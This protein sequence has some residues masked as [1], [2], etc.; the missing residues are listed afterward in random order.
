MNTFA[1]SLGTVYFFL[2]AFFYSQAQNVTL[3]SGPNLLIPRTFH[4][5]NT[6]PN[7]NL[8]IMGGDDGN[9]LNRT[10]YASTEI[11][12]LATNTISA[13]PV[14]NKN[15]TQ[16]CSEQLPNGNILVVAGETKSGEYTLSAEILNAS[17]MTWSFTD[18]IKEFH[19]KAP[20][21]TKMKDG[22]IMI[23][24][25]TTKKVEIFDP[26]TNKWT[27][28][29]DMLFAHGEGM[30]LTLTSNGNIYAMGG[31]GALKT[32]EQ[33]NNSTNKWEPR[34]NTLYSRAYHKV[35]FISYDYVIIT[36]CDPTVTVENGKNYI[37]RINLNNG[38]S[39]AVYN[40]KQ[41]IAHDAVKMD[42]DNV[43]IYQLGNVLNPTNTEFLSEYNTSTNQLV[44]P[45]TFSV[46]GG[47]HST[48][49]KLGN[50]KIIAI[51]GDAG[52]AGGKNTTQIFNQSSYSGCVPP[53]TNI[54]ITV[55]NPSDCYGKSASVT[56][57]NLQSGTTYNFYVSGKYIDF[58][59]TSA[60]SYT[61]TIPADLL[62]SGDNL[63]H[64]EI[65]KWGCPTLRSANTAVIS[66]QIQDPSNVSIAS[67]NNVTQFCQGTPVN[68]SVQNPVSTGIY[69]WS[70]NSQGNQISVNNATSVTVRHV[71][72][73]GCHSKKSNNIT[74]EAVSQ[75]SLNYYSMNICNTASP[76]TLPL[77]HTIGYWTGTGISNG[78][79]FSPSVAGPGTHILTY[80]YCTY[81][82][83][84]TIYVGEIIKPTYSA[85]NINLPSGDTLCSSSYINMTA[86]NLYGTNYRFKFYYDG[87]LKSQNSLGY[88]F[89]YYF[90][91][92][93]VEGNHTYTFK[94]YS[95]NWS[96]CGQDTVIIN[97]TY[98]MESSKPVGLTTAVIQD[99]ACV[100]SG[101]KIAVVNP[102]VGE[103]Y[104]AIYSSYNLEGKRVMTSV[105]K[106]TIF[107]Y[108][109]NTPHDP[110]TRRS[111][112]VVVSANKSCQNYATI[113]SR[114]IYSYD[115]INNLLIGDYYQQNE[116][117]KPT[118][119]SNYHSFEWDVKGVN[120][121][122]KT[123][124]PFSYSQTGDQII[125]VV[126]TSRYGCIDTATKT[127]H[128][129]TNIQKPT[130]ASCVFKEDAELGTY[131]SPIIST[132][133]SEGNSIRVALRF[134]STTPKEDNIFIYKI[135]KNGNKL[136]SINSSLPQYS[137]NARAMMVNAVVCDENNNIYIGGNYFAKTMNL[138]NISLTHSEYNESYAHAFIAKITPV[139]VVE[140]VYVS[141]STTTSI[142]INNV[143]TVKHMVY[144]SGM[145]YMILAQ[146]EY[147]NLRWKD[148]QGNIIPMTNSFRNRHSVVAL[149]LAQKN[150][151]E[152]SFL[153]NVNTSGSPSN[154]VDFSNII[155]HVYESPNYP[156]Q[157]SYW[158]TINIHNKITQ[159]NYFNNSL[160]IEGY[161]F[162]SIGF[163]NN[164]Y[165][166][167]TT[168]PKELVEFKIK[169]D[170]TTG[171]WSDYQTFASMKVE[172]FDNLY[173]QNKWLVYDNLSNRYS[174]TLF[175]PYWYNTGYVN[176]PKVLY[177]T[178]AIKN[179]DEYTI[180]SESSIIK[181]HD[182]NGTLKW[183]EI[184][185]GFIISDIALSED[186]TQ[187]I[188]VGRKNSG[189]QF[190][191]ING[192]Y[193]ISGGN[194]DDIAIIG[195]SASNGT[196][197][198]Q[199]SFGAAIKQDR[200][201]FTE[202][203]DCNE[204]R[205]VTK[206]A[207]NTN[208]QGLVTDNINFENQTI[209]AN[210]YYDI[211]L[212]LAGLCN[213]TDCSIVTTTP[214][215]TSTQTALSNNSRLSAV[216]PN[217]SLGEIYVKSLGQHNI[218]DVRV[219]NLSGVPIKEVNAVEKDEY[220]LN[221]EELPSGVYLIEVSLDNQ[222]KAVHKVV[223][224]E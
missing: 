213:S 52:P 194:N 3:Q 155:S 72:N 182:S 115:T 31:T 137:F 221:L 215:A 68:I 50:G 159:L 93:L 34:T 27:Y 40:A 132:V 111:L 22:R 146:G 198:W 220:L 17:T 67:A 205:I 224:V 100:G 201:A 77:E 53:N 128:I 199:T 2:I 172:N 1:K 118:L 214:I 204:L 44:T 112:S 148:N 125:K 11:Y 103:Y 190:M 184:I 86:N 69:L 176:D 171:V 161:M 85:S 189:G 122:G 30:T 196:L 140:W 129:S 147:T 23:A 83:T 78:N 46:Y 19:S 157:T 91:A 95:D 150:M 39:T 165:T 178:Y 218:S 113:S 43:L 58:V 10:F 5:V 202:F 186:E 110:T 156:D 124:T 59:Y 37:E 33:Y 15:R 14:L 74:L 142:N 28:G 162:G 151:R 35:T 180:E 223:L 98:Y 106:D 121:L 145:L 179:D 158:Y 80:N 57:G 138:Q 75:K 154:N 193:S 64:V 29:P 6:L 181:M 169:L 18:S 149:D 70:N 92:P 97:K 216:Y 81:S 116:L 107:I 48:I 105:P 8:I 104:S 192:Q 166:T 65:S 197:Q 63:F 130:Q 54:S 163:G 153:S 207:T 13:G 131:E 136:W 173:Y 71:D 42:N 177:N 108:A 16:F 139:G 120:S 88:N 185:K 187:L 20:A 141:E 79:I 36:G 191:L 167:N 26:E 144:E 102:V 109:P 127:I 84:Q 208:Y 164:T 209:A 211:T 114:S 219:L 212:P 203:A 61:L 123:I 174:N 12:D 32:I 73:N 25:G 152:I 49:T 38:Y 200:I 47:F 89:Q 168:T 210:L 21:I 183:K 126:S 96:V 188:C 45:Q 94:I 170:V 135:D 101:F 24:G 133:D 51:G 117:V 206:L 55:D 82:T 119:V 222:T 195:L 143:Q 175:K 99:T 4:Q 87:V 60:A 134:S 217:P 160:I 41:I 56:I 62:S 9:S 90:Y 7:G 66:R 76:I